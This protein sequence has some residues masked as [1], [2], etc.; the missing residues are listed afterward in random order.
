MSNPIGMIHM[1]IADGFQAQVE[2]SKIRYMVPVQ[3]NGGTIIGCRVHL[4]GGIIDSVEHAEVIAER[5]NALVQA[6][7]MVEFSQT[8]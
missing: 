3:S 6:A 5:Y 1:E 7:R 4:D 8:A 2:A